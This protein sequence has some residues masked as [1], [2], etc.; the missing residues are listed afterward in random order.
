[1]I[2]FV[3]AL[4]ALPLVCR[5]A[6]LFATGIVLGNLANRSAYALSQRAERR[7]SARER[8]DEFALRWFDRLPLIGWVFLRRGHKQL[9][10][11]FW[12]RWLMVEVS[13][14]SFCAALYW[15]EV[16]R[17]TLLPPGAVGVSGVIKPSAITWEIMHAA[18]LSHVVLAFFMLAAMLAHAGEQ[19]SPAKITA[20]GTLVGLMLASAYPWTMMPAA[21]RVIRPGIQ[22]VEFVTLM[23]PA[24]M[25]P[26]QWPAYL[27]APKQTL[28]LFAGLAIYCCWCVSQLPWLWLQNRGVEKAIRLFI[29]HATRAPRFRSTLMIF[30]LGSAGITTVWRLGGPGWAALLSSLAGLAMGGALMSSLRL[31]SSSV[32]GNKSLQS[33]EVMLLAMIGT[34]LGWQAAIFVFFIALCVAVAMRFVQWTFGLRRGTYGP[35]LCL[36]TV[37]VLTAWEWLWE[38]SLNFFIPLPN[39]HALPA[40]AKLLL[41]PLPGIACPPVIGLLIDLFA[42]GTVL[43]TVRHF[44]RSRGKPKNLAPRGPRA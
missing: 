2:H 29:G 7:S 44:I 5:L 34:Y 40:I 36:S 22:F 16:A 24:R 39:G 9:G 18:F 14:G 43:A 35:S 12:T 33:G 27:E 30:L 6:A 31:V 19:R 38:K 3:E 10:R 1:M 4:V 8:S 17:G 42:L 20:H 15:W 23:F 11:G 37:M 13:M 28:P 25:Y 32:F 26:E 21:V 41:A